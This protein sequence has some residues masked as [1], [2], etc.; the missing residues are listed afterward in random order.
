MLQD[1]R[2]ALVT[3]SSRGLGRVIAERLARDGLAVAV[4]GLH[5]DRPALEVVD[6]I[7]HDGGVAGAFAADVTDE[8][9]V[10]DLVAAVADRFGPIDVLVAQRDRPAA[11]GAP[12]RRCVGGPPRATRVLRQESRSWYC[13]LCFPR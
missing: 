4:N 8:A 11:G 10:T 2:V 9:Q 6:A 7:Q 3:G 5:D 12:R 13:A 1:R